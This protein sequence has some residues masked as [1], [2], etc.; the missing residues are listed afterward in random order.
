M[1]G[2]VLVHGLTAQYQ[3]TPGGRMNSFER[4]LIK[5]GA[6]YAPTE[7]H[8]FIRSHPSTMLN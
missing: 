1:Y 4:K 6:V 3:T 5:I 8:G 2:S 7:K